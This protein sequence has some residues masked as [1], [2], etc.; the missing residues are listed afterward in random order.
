MKKKELEITLQK[1][2]KL[3]TPQANLEQYSTPSFIA[4]DILFNAFLLGDI[5]KPLINSGILLTGLTVSE[6]SRRIF[7]SEDSLPLKVVSLALEGVVAF[8]LVAYSAKEIIKPTIE[9][10]RNPRGYISKYHALE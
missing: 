8:S 9:Y 5:K 6:A 3:K 10:L 4:S 7:F 1:I 2:P